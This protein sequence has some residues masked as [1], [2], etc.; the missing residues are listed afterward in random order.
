MAGYDL[1]IHTLASDGHLAPDEVVA[2]AKKARLEGIAITDHDTIEGV[3]PAIK[4]ALELQ[5]EIIPGVE[6]SA[7]DEGKEIHILGYRINV[8]DPE[9][10]QRLRFLRGQRQRRNEQMIKKLGQLGLDISMQE[11]K[12]SSHKQHEDTIGRP[13]IAEALL[14]KGYVVSMQHAFDEYLAEGKK[15]YVSQQRVLPIE[16][17]QWIHDAGGIAV[18]AHPGLLKDDALVDRLIQIGIDG[19]EAGHSDHSPDEERKYSRMANRYGLLVTAGSDF[20]GEQGGQQHHGA[21]G[22]R[23]CDKQALLKWLFK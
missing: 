3:K 8:D 12:A 1:H 18:I 9:F 17:V 20:H 2:Q 4:A 6:L 19:I 15:A 13:H 21:I 22:N 5:L 14:R 16:A 10:L 11:I 23:R 7:H